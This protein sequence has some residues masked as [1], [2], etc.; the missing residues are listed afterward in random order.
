MAR[1]EEHTFDLSRILSTPIQSRISPT[2][3]NAILSQ[4]PFLS[5]PGALNIRDIS[6]S[7]Y[8]RK[9]LVYRSGIL[10]HITPA[11]QSSLAEQYGIRTIFDLRTRAERNKV[12]DPELEGVETLWIPSTADAGMGTQVMDRVGPRDF[13]EEDG[14]KGFLKIYI[15]ILESH[16]DAF[17]AVFIRLRDE[18]EGGVLFHCTGT[19]GT[20]EY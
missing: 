3:V 8:V 20:P 16:K 12:P 1:H 9:G 10:G 18:K 11:G 2:I 5:I 6:V 4:H 13:I 17:K 7:P 14:K 19:F 15:N